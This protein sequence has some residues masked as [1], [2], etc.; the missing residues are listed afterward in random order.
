M[1]ATLRP[2]T[3]DDLRDIPDDGQRYEVIGGELVV[4]PAPSADHQRVVGSVYRL[5]FVFGH[6]HAAGE[7]LLAPFDVILSYF[8]I[9]QPDVVFMA[10]SQPRIA[11]THHS[12]D[13]P[14]RIVVEVISPASRR[15]DSVRK[16]AL[17]ARAGVPEYWIADPER[18]LLVIN[19]L[20]GDEYVPVNPDDSGLLNSR[21]LPGLRVD[22]ADIF[23]E[24]D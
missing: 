21:V 8:D 13:G 11:G 9:V 24:L 1:I 10:A 19:V 4:N 18:R 2:L 12:T 14:P 3:Y 6:N 20:M 7:A 22:P 17:Y 15:T 23:A 16:M 5:L